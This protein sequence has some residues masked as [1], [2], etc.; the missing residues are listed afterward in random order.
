[1]YEHDYDNA[2]IQFTTENVQNHTHSPSQAAHTRHHKLH[3]LTFTG[4]THSPSQVAHTHLHKLHTL[5]FTS[6]THSPSQVAH[7]HLHKLHTLTFTSWSQSTP[8][9]INLTCPSQW[10]T[11]YMTSITCVDCSTLVGSTTRCVH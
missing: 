5:T 7:T 11:E 3:T 9:S 4:C 10:S 6:C 2:S 8:I 1:M